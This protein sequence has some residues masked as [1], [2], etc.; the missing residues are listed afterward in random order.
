MNTTTSNDTPEQAQ[1]REML[2][3]FAPE[4]ATVYG[5]VRHVSA[6]GI[7]RAIDFY[8]FE[9]NEPR[10]I[11][12]YIA[13]LL[14]YKRNRHHDGLTVTGCGMDM[15]FSVVYNLAQELYGDGYKLNSRS[16]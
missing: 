7:T 8:T 14:D 16:L 11:S 6:S 9:N 12:G 1:A 3:K 5:I 4:G 2:H 13:A 15:I 10:M